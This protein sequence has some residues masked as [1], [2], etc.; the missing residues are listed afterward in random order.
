MKHF[1][2][3]IRTTLWLLVILMVVLTFKPLKD[4]SLG[5]FYLSIALLSLER[6]LF[7]K[8]ILWEKRKEKLRQNHKF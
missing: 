1:T 2:L 7:L 3:P 8:E 6:W 4:H 5:P